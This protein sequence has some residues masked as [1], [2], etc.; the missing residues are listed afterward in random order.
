M[1][2]ASYNPCPNVTIPKVEQ[3]EKQI[4]TKKEVTEILNLLENEPLKYRTFF[5]LAIFSGFRKGEL[6]GLEWKDVDFDNN[7]INVRRMSC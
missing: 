7:I 4:Y 5:T 3:K 1:G 2:V 6:L